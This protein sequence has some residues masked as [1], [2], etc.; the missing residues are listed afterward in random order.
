M[1]AQW[2]DRFYKTLRGHT[3]I[4]DANFAEIADAFGIK[5]ES[6]KKP[7]EVGPALNRMLKHKGPYVLDVKYP[8]NDKSRGHV[9]P[10]IPANHTYLDTFLDEEHTLRAYWKK[11]GLLKE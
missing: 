5:S 8:Y 2:E 1:V 7:E 6:I 4:G 10:M 11:K 9:M 3:Y